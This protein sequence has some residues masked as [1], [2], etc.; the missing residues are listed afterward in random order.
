MYQHQYANRMSPSPRDIETGMLHSVALRPRALSDG[1]WSSS[2][3]GAVPNIYLTPSPPATP[4]KR[5]FSKSRLMTT[6]EVAS[7][8]CWSAAFL[9]MAFL[10]AYLIGV[11][12]IP[13]APVKC[14][15]GTSTWTRRCERAGYEDAI[16]MA[17]LGYIPLP[18]NGA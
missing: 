14:F 5:P 6:L 10:C 3:E 15:N 13:D 18:Q 11:L 16:G 1:G 9:T 8:V 17:A 12:P 7:M 2:S 4:E